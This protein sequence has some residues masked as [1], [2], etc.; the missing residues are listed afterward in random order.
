MR[1]QKKIP[2]PV[3]CGRPGDRLNRANPLG[4]GRLIFFS[5]L[6]DALVSFLSL[7]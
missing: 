4:I 1:G 6:L 7:S 2:R 3:Y 5:L